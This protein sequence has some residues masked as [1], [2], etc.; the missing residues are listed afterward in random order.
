MKE[1]M[2]KIFLSVAVAFCAIFAVFGI[3]LTA[4]GVSEDAAADVKVPIKWADV[5]EFTAPEIGA[6]PD[7]AVTPVH[8]GY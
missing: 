6:L 1:R 4:Q 7:M 8:G 2:R 5:E 3:A